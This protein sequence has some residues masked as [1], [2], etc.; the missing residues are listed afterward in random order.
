MFD[1]MLYLWCFFSYREWQT[2]SQSD[3]CVAGLP[4]IESSSVHPGP[5]QRHS[6]AFSGHYF[7]IFGGGDSTL[8]VQSVGPILLHHNLISIVFMS[9]TTS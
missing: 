2:R 1:L 6:A 3:R 9:C 5:R 7:Y 4:G 8:Y